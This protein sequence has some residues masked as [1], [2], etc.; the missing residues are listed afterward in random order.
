MIDCI[1]SPSGHGPNSFPEVFRTIT[2]M[3][4]DAVVSEF[5]AKQLKEA[6]YHVRAADGLAAC[7]DLAADGCRT[8]ILDI[9]MGEAREEEGLVA[10]K[11]LKELYKPV[12]CVL[13]THH[14]DDKFRKQARNLGCDAFLNKSGRD[15]RS[16]FDQIL[17]AL[18]RMW[19][20]QATDLSFDPL[21]RP[22]ADEI[23][24]RVEELRQG[25]LTRTLIASDKD[26]LIS[27]YRDLTERDFNSE[28][29]TDEREELDLITS[30]LESAERL[31]ADQMDMENASGRLGKLEAGLDRVSEL[32][33]DLRETRV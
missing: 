29:S 16:D 12:F 19:L 18:D 8:F 11:K 6:K 24:R 15:L 7:Q 32:L 23:V 25:S 33:R 17:M 4:D 30:A 27:R 28:L 14:R 3:E 20:S 2:I 5:V 10:L 31:E 13:L 9:D 26:R 22:K 21:H 1:P